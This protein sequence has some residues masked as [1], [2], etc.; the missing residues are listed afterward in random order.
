METIKMAKKISVVA[1]VLCLSL[2]ICSC[3]KPKTAEQTFSLYQC[4]SKENADFLGCISEFQLTVGVW[5]PPGYYWRTNE[6]D[7]KLDKMFREKNLEIETDA[8]RRLDK[9]CNERFASISQ[10]AE[11]RDL[12]GWH[13]LEPI[14]LRGI[15]GNIH[16]NSISSGR[17]TTGRIDG[18]FGDTLKIVFLWKCR[19]TLQIS[20]INANKVYFSIDKK[21]KRPSIKLRYDIGSV[22]TICKS[23]IN[24]RI[25]HPNEFVAVANEA[26]IKISPQQVKEFLDF[27]KQ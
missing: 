10:Y 8:V 7:L 5:V 23:E 22:E 11:E 16:G 12:L 6:S 20:Q 21:V 27:I 26:I 3:N 4:A 14:L 15:E 9:A 19:G 24:G 2:V 1:I 13:Y 18:S 17:H 25:A